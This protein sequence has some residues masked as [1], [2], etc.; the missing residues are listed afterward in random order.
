LTR[1]LVLDFG[2]E[3]DPR[4]VDLSQ[5]RSDS[6]AHRHALRAFGWGLVEWIARQWDEHG[7][8]LAA[9]WERRTDELATMIAERMRPPAADTADDYLRLAG[10]AAH[11]ALAAE[12]RCA[13]AGEA[14]IDTP[15]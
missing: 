2:G 12:I 7:D 3:D 14:G 6:D 11:L 15:D 9:T 4:P 8:E 1:S 5:M 13:Y 10:N